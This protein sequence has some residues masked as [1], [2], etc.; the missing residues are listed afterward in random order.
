MPQ[1]ET[2]GGTTL[3]RTSNAIKSGVAD[4]TPE[5]VTGGTASNIRHSLYNACW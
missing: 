2:R 4:Q 5:K 3:Q 1:S